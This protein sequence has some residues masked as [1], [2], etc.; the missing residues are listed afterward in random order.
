MKLILTHDVANLGVA[1]DV[2]TVKDGYGRNYLL[3]RSYAM[4]WTKGA[5]KQID[6]INEARRKRTIESLED[7][8]ALRD[9]LQE[10]T[11]EIEKSAGE[12]GR[13]FGAVTPAEIAEAATA[14]S[15]KAIDRHAVTLVSPIKSVGEYVAHVQL[16][17]DVQAVLKVNVKATPKK[18]K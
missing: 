8:N 14:A 5:Q 17:K 7:A 15:G 2:V 3:P 4:L 1:G 6:Q 16:H 11:I 12:N 13:L 18:R 9:T 10:L